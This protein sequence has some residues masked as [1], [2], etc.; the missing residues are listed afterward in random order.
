M[1]RAKLL[2]SQKN[3]YNMNF[4]SLLSISIFLHFTFLL[5][6]QTDE[7]FTLKF[8][9]PHANEYGSHIYIGEHNE[10]ISSSFSAHIQTRESQCIFRKI[11][12]DGKT[13]WSTIYPDNDITIFSIIHCPDESFI[14]GGD[15]KDFSGKFVRGQS[16]LIKIDSK[17]QPVWEKK[18]QFASSDNCQS[19]LFQVMWNYGT[20]I[21]TH[22]L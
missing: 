9:T 6:A 22:L 21:I 7:C 11:G 18:Y 19:N 16:I 5:T 10:I 2:I 20:G 15:K 3:K 12:A 13:L 4:F 14:L 1:A 8:N 17:G